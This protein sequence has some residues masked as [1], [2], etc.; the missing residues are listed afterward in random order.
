M[1][2]VKCF[3]LLLLFV[4]CTQQLTPKQKKRIK[5]ARTKISC[6]TPEGWKDHYPRSRDAF[7]KGG[8]SFFNLEGEHIQ[9]SMCQ[10]VFKPKTN[11][12]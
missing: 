12:R 3:L 7:W 10:R 9:S 11:K 6:F 5:A 2:S 4:G 1:N 8:W